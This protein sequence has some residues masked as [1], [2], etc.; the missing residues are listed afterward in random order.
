M[1]RSIL[2]KIWNIPLKEWSNYLM[3]NVFTKNILHFLSTDNERERLKAYPRYLP[4]KTTLLGKEFQIIDANSFLA[5]YD[6]IITR[7]YYEFKADT[8]APYI[9]D[10]GANIGLSVAFFKELYPK[11]K[12]LAFEPANNVFE[13]LK[14]NIETF[15]YSDVIIEE[16]AVWTE[17]GTL[18]FF[19]EG[20][21][22]SRIKRST[23]T[24]NLTKVQSKRLKDY[25]NQKID[26]L[27][28]D[29]EGA[30]YEVILDC[31]ENLSL[32]E[33]MFVEYH[34]FAGE[35]QK[36]PELLILLKESGFRYYIKEAATNK[37]PFI[38]PVT[39]GMDLQ[40]NIFAYRPNKFH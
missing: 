37:N 39:T 21:W 33:N 5:M 18:E 1:I 14:K 11:S 3:P 24:R 25:I 30:E 8:D 13:L 16:K 26:F 38:A 36:L 9:I 32:V 22:G 28:I 10:C 6:E 27:K 35:E 2:W 19:I 17:D 40:L 12:I 4:T 31:K 34:S 7:K 15:N 20:S 23:D 29:I